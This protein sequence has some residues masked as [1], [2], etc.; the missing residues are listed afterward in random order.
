MISPFGQYSKQE[1]KEA[2]TGEAPGPQPDGSSI[3]Q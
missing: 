1:I 3:L 2:L